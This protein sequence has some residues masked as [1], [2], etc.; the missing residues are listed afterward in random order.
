MLNE[1]RVLS[2]SIV[3]VAKCIVS[4][5]TI[6]VNVDVVSI[7]ISNAKFDANANRDDFASVIRGV[8]QSSRARVN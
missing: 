7:L 4:D 3:V 6:C 1:P 2:A 5:Q 8:A